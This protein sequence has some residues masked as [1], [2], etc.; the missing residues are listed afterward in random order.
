MEE[1]INR[2]WSIHTVNYDSDMKR[3][4]AL[5][6][7]TVWMDL[8]TQCSAREADTEGRAVLVCLGS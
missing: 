8:N 4:E 5:T 1:G 2:M 7:A 6:Q 3:S